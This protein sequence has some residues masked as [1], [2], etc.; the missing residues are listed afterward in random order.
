MKKILMLCLAIQAITLSAQTTLKVEDKTI[1][2]T[3]K[4]ISEGGKSFN[5]YYH[6]DRLVADDMFGQWYFY[7]K[8]LKI[9]EAPKPT[10][11]SN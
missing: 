6:N 5:Q 3:V 4:T 7:T 8:R 1:D 2:C 9:K 10:T 11:A